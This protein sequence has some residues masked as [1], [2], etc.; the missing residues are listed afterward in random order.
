MEGDG[1]FTACGLTGRMPREGQEDAWGLTT[2]MPG[3]VVL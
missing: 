3:D 2:L 1:V